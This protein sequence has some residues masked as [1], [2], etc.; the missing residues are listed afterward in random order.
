MKKNSK[1]I[2]KMSTFAKICSTFCNHWCM[3]CKD[4]ENS[5]S[6]YLTLSWWRP[7]WLL[8]FL[9]YRK[10]C[11]FQYNKRFYGWFH[12]QSHAASF[13]LASNTL[14]C[15]AVQMKTNSH[16]LCENAVTENLERWMCDNVKLRRTLNIWLCYCA[17][18]EPPLWLCD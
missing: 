4:A 3:V 1:E 11:H 2:V 15:V 12:C 7:Q 6:F 17:L 10:L 9:I 18:D 14:S 13:I 5:V 16:S 8:N